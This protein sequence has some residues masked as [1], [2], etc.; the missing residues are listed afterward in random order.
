[1]AQDAATKLRALLD[2]IFEDSIVNAQ[3]RA[4]LVDLRDSGALEAAE[5]EAVFER[6]AEDKW[7]EAMA[8]GRLTP[9]EKTLML[10]IVRELRLPDEKIPAQLR[11]ALLVDG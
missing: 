1:M 7:G 2:Q 9:Q 3:E 11:M 4:A 6:F 10:G 5:V 8:D